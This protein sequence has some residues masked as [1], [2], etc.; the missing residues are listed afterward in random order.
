[1]A[2][3]ADVVDVADVGAGDL[4]EPSAADEEGSCCEGAAAASADVADVGVREEM[5]EDLGVL[6]IGFADEDPAS[7]VGRVFAEGCNSSASPC[8]ALTKAARDFLNADLST[9]QSSG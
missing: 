6:T 7:V 5:L 3:S 9:G 8:V 2:S 1:M 4:E